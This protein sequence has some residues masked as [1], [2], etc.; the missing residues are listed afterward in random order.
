[1]RRIIIDL[2]R[3][4]RCR[5]GRLLPEADV[6]DILFGP[7]RCNDCQSSYPV[8]EGIAD[9]VLE[10]EPPRGLQRSFEVPWVARAWERYLR[11]SLTL[12][13]SRRNLDRD[14]EYLLY[15]S[16]LGR[17]EAP[18]LDLGCGTALFARR[19]ARDPELPPV[20]GM[21]VSKPML[22][23]AVAQAREASAMVDFVRA[24]APTLPFIDQSLDAVLQSGSLHLLE[25]VDT[26]FS[27]IAR[28]LRPGGRYVGTTYLPPSSLVGTV[29]RRAGLHPRSEQA[30]RSAMGAA[31]LLSFERM[32]LDPFLLVTAQKPVR[33]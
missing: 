27:E 33:R 13:V 15:R 26:L 21:D 14:S 12:A 19:L 29:H 11:P 9:L 28:V 16:L 24:E 7:L 25:D 4:P 1:M 6:T 17:P 32:V 20:I 23:E 5:R 2:L 30:L 8:A 18:I 3:C 31:G 22:E 10:R